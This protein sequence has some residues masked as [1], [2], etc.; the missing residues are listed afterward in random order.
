MKGLEPISNHIQFQELEDSS[1]S[2]RSSFAFG[3]Y[4]KDPYSF[5]SIDLV[6][7]LDANGVESRPLL[8]GNLARHPY[9]KLYCEE[10]RVGLENSDKIHKG[11]LYLPN[12]QNLREDDV[13]FVCEKVIEFFRQR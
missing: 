13:D 1:K 10:P 9:Y 12:H 11:G 2:I 5:S 7:F 6:N 4:I 3:F 8:A